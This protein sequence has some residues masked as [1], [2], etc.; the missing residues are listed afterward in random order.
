MT[1][2]WVSAATGP[3]LPL[4]RDFVKGDIV[5]VSTDNVS[6]AFPLGVLAY[7]S[8]VF[9]G[10]AE[11]PRSAGSSRVLPITMAS[12]ATLEVLLRRLDPDRTLLLVPSVQVLDELLAV[13]DAF[14][15]RTSIIK[16]AVYRS[17]LNVGVKYAFASVFDPARE[18]Q[19]ALEC[20]DFPRIAT[21]CHEWEQHPEAHI[22]LKGMFKK[23]GDAHE[24]FIEMFKTRRVNSADGFGKRCRK[25]PC[26]EFEE[27]DGDWAAL[28]ADVAHNLAVGIMYY[29]KQGRSKVMSWC[30]G[31]VE[32]RT[33][34]VRMAAHGITTW[35]ML[36]D[37]EL[38][39]R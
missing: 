20:L 13:I 37:S 6:F 35:K 17:S 7:H 26:K 30:E 18:H 19:W 38:W 9:R 1:R 25:Q 14:D 10:L 32:C 29:P 22:A 24:K 33:C 11:L 4:H 3:N 39:R 21:D 12:A 8:P 31:I 16:A 5:L 27:Y 36:V 15:F 23:W 2:D 28:K 34:A